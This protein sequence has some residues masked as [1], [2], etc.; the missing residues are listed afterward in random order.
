MVM[1]VGWSEVALVIMLMVVV[2]VMVMK[3]TV[4]RGW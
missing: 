1:M 3:L 4:R 2:F